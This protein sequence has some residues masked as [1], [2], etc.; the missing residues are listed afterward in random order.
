MEPN[1]NQQINTPQMQQPFPQAVPPPI[2]IPQPQNPKKR[3]GKGTILFIIILL[4]ILMISVYLLYAINEL[5]N[6]QEMSSN[7]ST[8]ILPSYA[9]PPSPTPSPKEEDIEDIDVESPEADLQ[10]L[11]ADVKDL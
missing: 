9:P 4:L 10:L 3:Y 1:N 7:N 2:Q 11:D 8:V 5:K 6:T